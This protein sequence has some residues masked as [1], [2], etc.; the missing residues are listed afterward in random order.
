[1]NQIKWSLLVFV[2]GFFQDSVSQLRVEDA[3]SL[4]DSGIYTRVESVFSPEMGAWYDAVIQ[5]SELRMGSETIKWVPSI[6]CHGHYRK[7]HTRMCRL[8]AGSHLTWHIYGTVTESGNQVAGFYRGHARMTVKGAGETFIASI[9]VSYIVSG[10]KPSCMISQSGT[11]DFGEV[12]AH[13]SGLVSLHSVT[14]Q[15]SAHGYSLQ[16]TS[17]QH[18]FAHLTLGTSAKSVMVSVEAPTVLQSGRGIVGFRSQLSYKPVSAQKYLP[19]IEGSG[20]RRVPSDQQGIHFR[21]G[22]S[23][24]TYSTSQEADYQGNITLTVLCE[25]IY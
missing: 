7:T 1:M 2:C 13:T 6:S 14:G 19:L 25:Q 17:S 8:R 9:P 3:L 16:K 4:N 20:S 18:G 21:L 11:L 24:Q 10:S 15:R 23:V 5:G 22:G 12:E